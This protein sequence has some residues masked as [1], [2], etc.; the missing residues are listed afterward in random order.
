MPFLRARLEAVQSALSHPD[1]PAP[2]VL[3]GDLFLENAVFDR[4]GRVLLGVVDWEEMCLGPAL[5][6]VAMTLVGCGY[7]EDDRLDAALAEAFLTA[8]SAARPLTA[9]ERALFAT[10]LQYALLSIAFWRFRQ[11]NVRAPDPGRRHAHRSMTTRIHRLLHGDDGQ[12][13]AG[14]LHRCCGAQDGDDAQGAQ[15]VTE[16]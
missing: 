4:D 2:C 14:I 11:F 3:H 13:L 5:L 10:F 16:T 12:T 1:L 8:Y 9:V 6:D 7:G 15:A